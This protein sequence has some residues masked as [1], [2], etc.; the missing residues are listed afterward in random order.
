MP[1]SLKHQCLQ[2]NNHVLYVQKFFLG[3]PVCTVPECVQGNIRWYSKWTLEHRPEVQLSGQPLHTHL[4]APISLLSS[5]YFYSSLHKSLPWCLTR[6]L[7]VCRIWYLFTKWVQNWTTVV[8]NMTQSSPT[9]RTQLVSCPWHFKD[10]QEE[11]IMFWRS[12]QLQM[13]LSL[14]TYQSQRAYLQCATFSSILPS[15]LCVVIHKGT[16]NTKYSKLLLLWNVQF[17]KHWSKHKINNN[18]HNNIMII[19]NHHC[20]H[21]K[22][23]EIII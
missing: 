16:W 8:L 2:L 13:P 20:H 7:V 19:I 12:S 23:N 6:S 14:C 11:N 10:I 17:E 15:C 22:H 1:Q 9:A 18:N 5:K 21:H 3:F 4:K